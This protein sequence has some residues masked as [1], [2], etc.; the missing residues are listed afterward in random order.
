MYG[1][2]MD[3]TPG[4]SNP[5]PPIEVTTGRKLL[6]FRAGS[7]HLSADGLIGYCQRYGKV[8]R[9]H[10]DGF[11]FGACEPCPEL[12]EGPAGVDVMPAEAVKLP[13]G[14]E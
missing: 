9:C 1:F 10:W 6:A 14:L 13:D 2:P 8:Y 11:N 5:D 7:S 4:Q 12:V 3:Y